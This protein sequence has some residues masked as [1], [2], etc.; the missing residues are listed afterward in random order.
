MA[1]FVNAAVQE[2]SAV[3][4]PED[5]LLLS[6]YPKPFLQQATLNPKPSTLNSKL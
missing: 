1:S 6:R 4:P 5:L 3:D 2:R